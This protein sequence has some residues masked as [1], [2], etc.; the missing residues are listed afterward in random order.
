MASIPPRR[1]PRSRPVT[2]REALSALQD[3]HLTIVHILTTVRRY[4]DAREQLRRLDDRLELLLTRDDGRS[5]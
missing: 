5:R 2:Y 3:A 1:H 4:P